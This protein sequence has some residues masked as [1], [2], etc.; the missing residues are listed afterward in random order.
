MSLQR[1]P[2]H[3][4]QSVMRS[5]RRWLLANGYTHRSRQRSTRKWS[6][7]GGWRDF[8]RSG[9]N[10]RSFATRISPAL[11]S[12]RL[13]VLRSPFGRHTTRCM[14]APHDCWTDA[15]STREGADWRPALENV[16]D[17]SQLTLNWVD[18]SG[19]PVLDTGLD[20]LTLGCV[21]LYAS[22]LTPDNTQFGIA[23]RHITAAV[24]DSA[25]G[26]ATPRCRSLLA[27][28]WVEV[29]TSRATAVEDLNEAFEIAERG[30]MRLRLVDI[31]LQ[32]ARL[33]HRTTPYRGS[34]RAPISQLPA[35]S[36]SAAATGV[37]RAS[38]KTQKERSSL[39]RSVPLAALLC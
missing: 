24:D 33:F 36:Y 15:I 9:G 30:P 10:A 12:C 4:R 11:L 28:A 34:R 3:I 20:H 37:V 31:H 32:R 7:E 1:S 23:R 16:F 19:T 35:G 18:N 22:I 29:L 21:A 13:R 8:S 39:S 27:R 25:C 17:R 5:H 26:R 14:V 6:C 2:I 38:S